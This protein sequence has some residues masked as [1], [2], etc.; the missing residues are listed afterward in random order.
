MNQRRVNTCLFLIFC[1]TALN[2]Q[3]A[4]WIWAKQAGGS[5]YELATDISSDKNGHM[6]VTGSF[7]SASVMIG[8][9]QL[10]NGSL[11]NM[12]DFFIA[13]YDTAG[14]VIWVRSYGGMLSD[15][16]FGVTSDLSG[17]IFVTGMF[18]SDTFII[19]SDTLHCT[20]P[21]GDSAD[22]F[23]AAFD[24]LGNPL[25]ARSAAGMGLDEANG[26]ATDPAGNVYITGEFDSDTI[27]FGPQFLVNNA[28]GNSYDA[29][30]VKYDGGGNVIWTNAFGGT[31]Y[32]FSKS[33]TVDAN[34]IVTIA[35]YSQSDSIVSPT[36]VLLNNSVQGLSDGFV[37]R[38]DI[39]G[40]MLWSRMFGGASDEQISDGASDGS[41]NFF[42]CGHSYSGYFLFGS[43]SFV[44]HGGFV[45][46]IFLLK[47]DV[48][49]NAMWVSGGGGTGYD[50]AES[51][52]CDNA[53]NIFIG[54][55]YGSAVAYFG[56]DSLVNG[57]PGNGD[58]FVAQYDQSGSEV[59]VL[60]A[61][62]S[63]SDGLLGLA[64]DNSGGVYAVGA[65]Y[66]SPCQFGAVSL[67][68]SGWCDLFVAKWS[69][70]WT[71]I[72]SSAGT[73]ND[74]EIFPSP[75]TDFINITIEGCDEARAEFYSAEG[76][77]VCVCNLNSGTNQILT[78]HLA[79]GVYF[80]RI[81]SNDGYSVRKI[82]KR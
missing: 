65:F 81:T 66:S 52:T 35:G 23:V 72:S 39:S 77:S 75:F 5:Y 12:S 48:Q 20:D 31:N 62:G 40:T 64:V 13:K 57:N 24:P 26:I 49:G 61:G 2:A 71:G 34:G 27:H 3:V 32:E 18:N 38:Y 63:Q 50:N 17:N 82:I 15:D 4:S 47:Y 16:A 54:G 29:F 11:S 30:L 33:I 69:V 53:N 74:I 67:P 36:G 9:T 7:S 28:T 19:G 55:S 25:W 1:C 44:N 60:S 8:S 78:T 46:D 73:S 6:L 21:M 14:N 51:V 45:T 56:T 76:R 58:I 43:D 41:G 59:A 68:N 37:A 80:I 22:V 42:A 70:F 10:T 79:S